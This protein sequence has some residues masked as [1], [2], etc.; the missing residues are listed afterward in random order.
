MKAVKASARV[1]KEEPIPLTTRSCFHAPLSWET[2]DTVMH[3]A[4]STLP[5]AEVTFLHHYMTLV[6]SRM[7]QCCSYFFLPFVFLY[8][9]FIHNEP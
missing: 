4:N 9:V 5:L 7:N 3:A 6:F 8:A 1:S 2:H